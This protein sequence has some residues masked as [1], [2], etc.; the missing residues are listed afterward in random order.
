MK[1]I[2][3]DE[4]MGVI[5]DLYMEISQGNSLCSFIY[6]KQAKMSCFSFLSFL[7]FL[8]QS[9]RTVVLPR[10]VHWHQRKGGIVGESG[11]EGEYN[12]MRTH[13]SMYL[14]K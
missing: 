6:L 2:K 8:L 1:K 7:F 13:I 9:Q 10:G 14:H 12:E 4:P 3:G 5:T 11:Q